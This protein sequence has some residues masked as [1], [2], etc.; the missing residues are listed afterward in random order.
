MA[1]LAD[2]IRKKRSTGQS[3]TG[4]FFGSLKDKLKEGIDPRQ[5]LNQTGV[6]TALFPKLKAYKTGNI[7]PSIDLRP[8]QAVTNKNVVIEKINK[9]TSIFAKNTMALQSLGRD[10]NVSRRNIEK[11]VKITG[12]KPAT[13]TDIFF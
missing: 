11:L 4:S 8:N 10:F 2:V 1:S 7:S 5:L 12:V 6:L 9:N 13:K 3:R